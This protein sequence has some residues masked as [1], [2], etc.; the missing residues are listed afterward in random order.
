MGI[1][2]SLHMQ[3]ADMNV[4]SSTT[5]AFRIINSL[6]ESWGVRLTWLDCKVSDSSGVPIPTLKAV[7]LN[8]L[9]FLPYCRVPL[10][11]RHGGI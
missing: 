11:H 7:I 6:M 5:N 3:N 10:C 4:E 9:L 8:Y 1:H 2:G